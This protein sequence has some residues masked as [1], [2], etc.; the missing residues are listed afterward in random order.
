MT[1]A[2]EQ[3]AP[4]RPGP[5]GRVHAAW[6]ALTGTGAAASVALALLVLAGVFIAVAVPRASLGYRTQVLQRTFGVMSSSATTVLGDAD[7]SGHRG[8]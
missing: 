2:G 6:A 1:A 5:G 7:I 8:S 3:H 4:A